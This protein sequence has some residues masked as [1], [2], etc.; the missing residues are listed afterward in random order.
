M[1][2]DRLVQTAA[3]IEA[4][5]GK[6][7]SSAFLIRNAILLEYNLILPQQSVVKLRETAEERAAA[8]A[9]GGVAVESDKRKPFTKPPAVGGKKLKKSDGPSPSNCPLTQGEEDVEEERGEGGD[10]RGS[11]I[12]FF[13]LL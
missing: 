8:Q 11:W 4:I 7:R 12:S 3:E 9:K 13:I 6:Y 10:D 1:E 5:L 2:T